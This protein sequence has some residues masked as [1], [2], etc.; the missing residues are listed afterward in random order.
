[1]SDYLHD[2]PLLRRVIYGLCI[3][4]MLGLTALYHLLLRSPQ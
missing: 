4:L 3:L 1:M 2:L